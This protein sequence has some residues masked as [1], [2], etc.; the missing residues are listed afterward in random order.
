[1]C[2]VIIDSCFLI[3]YFA[4]KW[5][6]NLVK[7]NAEKEEQTRGLLDQL[8]KTY[9]QA[10]QSSNQVS[11]VASQI[12]MGNQEL[13][14]RTQEQAS[15]LEEYAATIV[16][17]SSSV[18]EVAIHS[19]EAGRISQATLT[20]V[21]EGNHSLSETLKAIREISSDSAQISEIIKVMNDIAFQTNL[22]ALNAA[23]EAAHA[24]EEGRGFAVVASEVRNLAVRAA[25]SAK[26]IERLIAGIIGH[27]QK[28]N[29]LAQDSAKALNQIVENTKKTSEVISLVSMAMQEE[30]SASQQIQTAIEQLNQ[31]TQ[32]NAA[33]VEEISA[34]SQSL[35]VEAENLNH[36]VD[37]GTQK[38]SLDKKIIGSKDQIK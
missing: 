28:G 29:Q 2:L 21:M 16:E 24:G 4:T 20:A 8:E 37:Q 1:A 30:S 5:G 34:S 6:N 22:L 35:R 32:E 25:E 18:Q 38:I 9:Q 23:V 17:V 7:S 33:L 11:R 14:Q 13:S 19:A 12:A 27:I 3:T 36:L 26:E 15:T 31:A 10:L